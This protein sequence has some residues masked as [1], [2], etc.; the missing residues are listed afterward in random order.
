MAEKEY[1][2]TLVR[3]AQEGTAQV[4][5]NCTTCTTKRSLPSS[6]RLYETARMR[7]TS[8]SSPF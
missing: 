1:I 3:A 7:R 2:I 8:C 4:L 6:A 5:P